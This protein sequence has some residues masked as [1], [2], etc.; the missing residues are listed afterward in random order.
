VNQ[1]EN[2]IGT[3]SETVEKFHF[4]IS[5]SGLNNHTTRE[6]DENRIAIIIIIIHNF[7][8]AELVQIT[9]KT[10]HEAWNDMF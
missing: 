10:K 1:K 3:N 7:I 6:D 2:E 9:E 8:R 5:M 4:I